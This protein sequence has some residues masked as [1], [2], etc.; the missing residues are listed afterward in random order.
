[1][2]DR[3]EPVHSMWCY[4]RAC[5]TIPARGREWFKGDL[6]EGQ[7]A[8][9]KLCKMRAHARRPPCRQAL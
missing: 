8:V 6:Y 2:T 7:D 5:R 3:D 4:H 1:M 9:A